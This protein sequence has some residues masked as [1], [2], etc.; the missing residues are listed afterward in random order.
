M[1]SCFPS[2]EEE[3]AQMDYF[4]VLDFE[5]TCEDGK[6]LKPQEIIEFPVLKVNARTLVT[7]SEFHTYVQPTAHPV[8]T[9]F[10]TELTGITQD[11]VADQPLLSDVMTSFHGWMEA[12]GLLDPG[13]KS[14]FVTCGDWDLKIMLPKQCSYFSIAIPKYMRQWVNIKH[15][16]QAVTGRKA[17]GMPGM[18]RD[19]GLTLDGR[20]HSGID[21]C[22]N[23]AKI[24][25]EL[26]KRHPN[27]QPTMRLPPFQLR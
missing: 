25:A 8:L 26:A 16:F 7:E 9:A 2:E 18:L 22:R 5:A 27:I 10:C 24:L 4:L 12:N 20:H 23:I 6:K 17:M 14:C 11:M 1:A 3:A 19:L 21:D 15:V 13:V